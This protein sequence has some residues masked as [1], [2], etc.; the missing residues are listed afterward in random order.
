MMRHSIVL[1]IFLLVAI[2]T[3]V[4]VAQSPSTRPTTGEREPGVDAVVAAFLQTAQ[5]QQE[6]DTLRQKLKE[7]HN[8]AVRLLELRITGYRTGIYDASSVFDAAQT[9]ADAKLDL[10][11]T[12]SERV[13]VIEQLVN[14]TKVGEA[15]LEQ[16]S[17]MGVVPEAGLLRA[18]LARQTAE[19]E[20]LKLKRSATAPAAPTTQP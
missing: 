9:V 19:A 6:D 8:T 20:L 11:E 7:R 17:Q 4:V 14:V 13:A 3:A 10:A 16:Q 18:R 15:R 5:V 12:H 1:L 2:A